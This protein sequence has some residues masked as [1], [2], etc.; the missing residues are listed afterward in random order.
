MA[1]TMS[2]D[3]YFHTAH[4]GG[5]NRPLLFLFHGTGGDEN[6]LIALGPELLPQAGVVAPRGDVSENGALRFFRRTGEGVYDMDDLG[7]RTDK[8]RGFIEAHV[9]LEQP[10]AVLGIGYSNGANILASVVFSAPALFDATVLDAS[11][12]PLRTP[13]CRKPFGPFDADHRRATRSDLP[14]RPD[15]TS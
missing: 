1:R 12:D 3:A 2:Q 8:M 11:A 6:Q 7:R 4:P 13:A 14:A 15:G 9:E 5:D 10:S